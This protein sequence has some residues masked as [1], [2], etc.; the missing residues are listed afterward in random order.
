[1]S[2]NPLALSSEKGFVY[3]SAVL[4]HC[5]LCCFRWSV[6]DCP[7]LGPLGLSVFL[8]CGST[9]HGTHPLRVALSVLCGSEGD[10]N[11]NDMDPLTQH[12]LAMWAGLCLV[13]WTC[14]CHC[15]AHFRNFHA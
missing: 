6:V 4:R 5:L 7:I 1:M 12:S 3:G 2:I 10:A 15:L 9:Y 14:M 8:P 11:Y 13:L